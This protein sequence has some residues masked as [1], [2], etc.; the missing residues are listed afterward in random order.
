MEM[1]LNKYILLDG[2]NVKEIIPEFNPKFPNIPITKRYSEKFIEQLMAVPADTE[3]EQNW[4]YDKY[5][6]SFAAPEIIE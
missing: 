2:N 4:T 5:T 6:G 1:Q 3:V